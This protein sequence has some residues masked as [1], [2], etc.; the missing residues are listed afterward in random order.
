MLH[1]KAFA[2]LLEA[3]REAKIWIRYVGDKKWEGPASAKPQFLGKLQEPEPL[4]L[5]EMDFLGIREV[6]V[7]AWVHFCL[8]KYLSS[9]FGSAMSPCC[10]P[11]PAQVCTTCAGLTGQDVCE[12]LVQHYC[13]WL[14]PK[15]CK[16]EQAEAQE[17]FKIMLMILNKFH[18]LPW[19]SLL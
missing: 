1:W 18:V 16:T 14:S 12:H 9:T 3:G 13:W 10:I 4:T 17:S 15:L 7:H 2:I 11:H 5:L 6:S 19:N 8:G